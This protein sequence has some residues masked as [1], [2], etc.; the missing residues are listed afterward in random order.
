MNDRFRFHVFL[1]PTLCTPHLLMDTDRRNVSHKR[2]EVVW[3]VVPGDPASTAMNLDH[4]ALI[5]GFAQVL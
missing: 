4:V 3:V 5:V 1:L 2:S